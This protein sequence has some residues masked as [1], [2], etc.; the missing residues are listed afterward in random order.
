[1]KNLKLS[2]QDKNYTRSLFLASPAKTGLIHLPP[3]ACRK[4]RFNDLL[5]KNIPSRF[6]STH[7]NDANT[8]HLLC[9]RQQGSQLSSGN[10][11]LKVMTKLTPNWLTGFA[12]AESSFAINIVKSSSSPLG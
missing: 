10:A 7:S 5:F 4:G 3:Q 2:N 6:Y 12:D 1:M 8:S 11:G 9:V